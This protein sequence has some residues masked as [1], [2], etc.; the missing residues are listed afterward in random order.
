MVVNRVV[1]RVEMS[2]VMH[3]WVLG[4]RIGGERT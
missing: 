1:R 4:L 2:V 3:G